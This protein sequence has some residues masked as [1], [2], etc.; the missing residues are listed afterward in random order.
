MILS[1]IWLIVVGGAVILGMGALY[2]GM[3]MYIWKFEAEQA[4]TPRTRSTIA[5]GTRIST[6]NQA[7][8]VNCI[9]HCGFL[10]RPQSAQ[11]LVAM[12]RPVVRAVNRYGLDTKILP[13]WR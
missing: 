8:F 9:Q 1:S 7:G 12:S 3:P 4:I 13:I 5:A 10:N 11:K 2:S 6:C